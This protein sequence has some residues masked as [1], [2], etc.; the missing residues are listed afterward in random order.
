MGKGLIYGT[1]T[2]LIIA[3]VDWTSRNNDKAHLPLWSASGIAVRWSV[4]ILIE[5][6]PRSPQNRGAVLTLTGE[7]S[8]EILYENAPILLWN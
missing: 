2:D 3:P 5:P 6:P 7:D 1:I 4:L 8:N